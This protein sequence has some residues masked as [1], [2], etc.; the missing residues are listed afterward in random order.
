MKIAAKTDVGLLR[1]QN[2]DMYGAGELAGGIGWAVVCDGMGGA[3]GGAIASEMA[4]RGIAD[5][6]VSVCREGM[7]AS[8]VRNLLVAAVENTNTGIYDIASSDR[9]LRGM[10]TT[11]VAAIILGNEISI[12]HVGDSRAYK[13][14]PEGEITQLTHD[15]SVVQEMV[16]RGR[17]SPEQA[18]E[19]PDRNIITRAIGVGEK[20]TPDFICDYLEPG[21][22][23]LICTD[24]LSGY[25][26]D[27]EMV[28]LISSGSFDECAVRLVGR[29]NA[30]G[31]GDNITVVVIEI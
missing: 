16:D 19:H 25:V 6:I 20:V 2:Q 7:P 22:R 3:A 29:A 26:S 13:I 1:S 5:R 27:E 10:G 17:L 12:A 28:E 21:D 31:G 15:H 14:S 9:E 18:R 4:V 23:V 24:G 11:A 30:N 8:M